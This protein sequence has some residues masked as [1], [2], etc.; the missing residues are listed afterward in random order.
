MQLFKLPIYSLL[1]F[2]LT[3]IVGA[4]TYAHYTVQDTGDLL[5]E[6]KTQAAA[7]LQLKTSGDEGLNV[8]GR[9]DKGFDSDSNLR[10]LFGAGTTDFEIGAFYK[11]VPFPDFEKQ[12]AIGFTFGAHM[13]RYTGENELAARFIPLI[14]KKFETDSGDFTP[15]FAIPMAFSNYNKDGFSPVQLV[16]GSRYKHPEFEHC[17]F[18]AELGFNL[19]DAFTYISV[20]AIFP[21]F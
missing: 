14:S 1:I 9:L 12:P 15:Y 19:H 11:W 21:A 6:D 13:A 2:T 7:E 4:S 18:T 3:L 5:P 17:D 20:G 16:L 8:I 10:F